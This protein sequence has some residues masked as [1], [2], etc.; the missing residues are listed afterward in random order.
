MKA[1]I[2]FLF[3][4][5]FLLNHSN[6]YAQGGIFDPALTAI[7]NGNPK[8][9]MPAWKSRLQEEELIANI[10]EKLTVD[11][12]NVPSG[13]PGGAT[14]KALDRENEEIALAQEDAEELEEDEEIILDT[15]GSDI[16]V[17]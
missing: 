10:L 16:V 2:L 4:F 1:K 11:V 13:Q 15:G 12:E 17:Q 3:L 8:K 9:G 7:K 6:S 14:N 5:Y